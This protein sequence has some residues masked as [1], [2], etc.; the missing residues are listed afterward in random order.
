ELQMKADPS[1]NSMPESVQAKMESSFNTDFSDVKIHANSSKAPAVGALAYAQGSDIHF[2]PGQY[3]PESKS[4]QELLGHELTHVVQQRQGRVKPTMQLKNKVNINDDR[5]LEQEADDMGRKAANHEM[6][7]IAPALQRSPQTAPALQRSPAPQPTATPGEKTG[8][9]VTTPK[10]ILIL[11]SIREAMKNFSGGKEKEK[12][13]NPFDSPIKAATYAGLGSTVLGGVAKKDHEDSKAAGVKDSFGGHAKGVSDYSGTVTDAIG[14]VKSLVTSAKNIYDLYKKHQEQGGLTGG[15]AAKGTI[16]ALNNALEAAQG[17]VKLAKSIMTIMEPNTTALADVIPGVGIAVA[18]VKIALKTVNLITAANSRSAMTKL[19]R[20]FK[21]KY[22]KSDFIKAKRWFGGNTGTDK[23]KLEERK[24]VLRMK[25]GITGDK[26]AEAELSDIERYE[27]AKEMKYI[28]V[29]RTDRA[30]VQIGVELTKIAGDIATLTGVGAQVGMPLKLVA[31]GVGGAMPIARKLKQSGRDRAAKPE[32]WGITKAVFNA[33]KS[34]TQKNLRRSMDAKL[35][36]DMVK[37]L[38]EYEAENAEVDTQYK[39]VK[40]FI[41]A[42]G[43]SLLYLDKFKGDPAKL[44][45]GL[46]EAMTQ[47]E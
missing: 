47:R 39:Q 3:N 25:I 40:D 22:A 42:T 23:K 16:T 5:S 18:G 29:K 13:E 6:P 15:E 26:A 37:R 44:R 21:S 7:D 2:A 17:S 9:P 33:E 32:A 31:A 38:P 14:I 4:G 19:K 1:S 36:L 35:I 46:I 41:E 10:P 8:T 28:N 27:L 30:I 12:T 43:V 24:N 45:D 11:I 20:E 34:T